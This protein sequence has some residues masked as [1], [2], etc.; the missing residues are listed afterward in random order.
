MIRNECTAAQISHADESERGQE[1]DDET[2][3]GKKRAA[4]SPIPPQ[5]EDG[6]QAEQC[7]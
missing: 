3:Q 7:N 6:E 4:R 2:G 1:R 5:P